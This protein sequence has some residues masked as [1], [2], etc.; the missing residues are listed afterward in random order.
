MFEDFLLHLVVAVLHPIMPLRFDILF[1][2]LPALDYPLVSP[3]Q[4]PHLLAFLPFHT[5]ALICLHLLIELKLGFKIYISLSLL[6]DHPFIDFLH[7][8][9]RAVFM[10][11]IVMLMISRL[12]KVASDRKWLPLR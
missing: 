12:E 2:P 9:A 1:F 4:Y 10:M 3:S 8:F 5:I 7:E 11:P 6:F